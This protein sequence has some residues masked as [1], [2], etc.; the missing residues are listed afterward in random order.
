MTYL[1]VFGNDSLGHFSAPKYVPSISG[2]LSIQFNPNLETMTGFDSLSSIGDQLHIRQTKIVDFPVF[3]MLESVNSLHLIG[4]SGVQ[5]LDWLPSLTTIEYL[6]SITGNPALSNCS[7]EAVCDFLPSSGLRTIYSNKDCCQNE[8]ILT[9][10]CNNI[11]NGG[12]E[13]CDGLDNN[14]N[15]I[16]DEGFDQDGDGFTICEGDCDDFNA[17]VNPGAEEIC[18]TFDNDCDGLVDEGFDQDNDTIADC[19]DNCPNVPNPDQADAD[20][21]GVGDLCDQW[22]GCDDKADSDGDG[23]SDCIDLDELSNWPCGNN[24]NNKVFYLPHTAGEP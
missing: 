1:G 9:D 10:A 20:C 11:G 15:G 19:I 24:N 3:S 23:I 18:D 14:C 6:L 16:I 4:N 12:E 22:P 7:I 21:D 17:F 5:N 13:V 8:S 2:N